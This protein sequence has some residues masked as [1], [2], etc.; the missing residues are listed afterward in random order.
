MTG[1]SG[2]ILVN[3]IIKVGK[4]EDRDQN[5]QE[6]SK[7][8]FQALEKVPQVSRGWKIPNLHISKMAATKKAKTITFESKE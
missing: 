4:I 6:C 2:V 3:I 5:W 1:I 8:P 7:Y